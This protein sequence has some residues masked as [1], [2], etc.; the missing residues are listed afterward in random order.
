MPS[1]NF[2]PLFKKLKGILKKHEPRCVVDLS[3]DTEYFLNAAAPGPKGKPDFFG[4]VSINKISISFYLRAVHSV[5][6]LRKSLSPALRKRLHGKSCF[7]FERDEPALFEEL[8]ALTERAAR[9]GGKP[10][11]D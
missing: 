6:A 8:A 9:Q 10:G 2:A 5:P 4:G 3:S 11:R 1:N 7:R